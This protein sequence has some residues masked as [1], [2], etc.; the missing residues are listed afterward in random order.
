MLHVVYEDDRLLVADKPADLVCHP[1]KGDETSSLIG[2]VRLHLG[3]R[4][5]RLVNRLDRETSG[6]VAVAKDS[7]AARELARLFESGAVTKTYLALVHGTLRDERLVDAPLGRDE[8]SEVAIKDRVRPDGATAST[9]VRPIRPVRVGDRSCTLVEAEPRT[10]RKHQIRIHLEHIGH[11]VVGD[12]LYGP[13]EQIYLRL[14][15]GEMTTADREALVVPTHA[16]HAW[17]LAF[18]WRERDWRFE[19][20]APV[21]LRALA[22]QCLPE[23]GLRPERSHY[24]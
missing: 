17:R 24:C 18:R 11:P 14:V 3:S 21:L 2:R 5:G 12:K 7:E 19:A 1:T 16:L 23:R 6:L 20:P 10:G 9:V 15:R 8:A 4:E 22:E 13:D